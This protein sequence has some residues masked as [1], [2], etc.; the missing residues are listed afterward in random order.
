[1][2]IDS[3]ID[4]S[5]YTMILRIEMI[6]GQGSIRAWHAQEVARFITTQLFNLWSPMKDLLPLHDVGQHLI[7]SKEVVGARSFCKA[8]SKYIVD[9]K[10]PATSHI[11]LHFIGQVIC[12]STDG[13]TL[14]KVRMPAGQFTLH[15]CNFFV[16]I[17]ADP[18]LSDSRGAMCVPAWSIPKGNTKKVTAALQS[19]SVTV[20]LP[21]SVTGE[22]KD[23][24]ILLDI[25]YLVPVP[26]DVTAA[27]QLLKEL[28][29]TAQS[30]EA[31]KPTP[32]LKKKL[33]KITKGRETPQLMD[34]D[35]APEGTQAT[36]FYVFQ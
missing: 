34:A 18:F 6:L 22:L 21:K 3:F 20:M 23:I 28:V 29:R 2:F 5:C 11:K 15:G 17:I 1:M 25:H 31:A 13:T 24:G 19:T 36:L 12:T 4:G 33:T 32:S 8:A 35:D 9:F 14:S 26:Q 30:W 16:N 27:N 10:D 7:L